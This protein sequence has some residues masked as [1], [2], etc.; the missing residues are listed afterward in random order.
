MASDAKPLEGS[1][2]EAKYR[3]LLEVSE[4]ANSHLDFV[5]V[6]ES[7]ARVLEPTVLLD[8][9]GVATVKGDMV[10]AHAIHVVGHARRSGESYVDAAARGFNVARDD[11][12]T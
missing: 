3:I 2:A 12:P 1:P 7:V 6:L 11:V 4:A 10:R 9:I 8:V 5:G